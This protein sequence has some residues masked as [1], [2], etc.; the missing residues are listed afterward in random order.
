MSYCRWSEDCEVYVYASAYGGFT[1][2][3]E[4]HCN[5]RLEL[6]D[7]LN[8]LK[9]IGKKVPQEV[10]YRLQDEI[11]RGPLQEYGVIERLDGLYFSL[12]EIK[13]YTQ[14]SSIVIWDE[15]DQFVDENLVE[16]IE[17]LLASPSYGFL[18]VSIKNK[19]SENI[20]Y[21]QST[22]LFIYWMLK[23]K[24]RRLLENWPFQRELLEPLAVD[25]GVSTWSE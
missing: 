15:Y 12:T 23:N 17:K 8:R 20:F 6:I 18:S 13:S 9:S 16:N 5:T 19:Y 7:E 22:V 14:K 10:I 2:A 1:I 11:N 24:K 4:G 25:M 3:G 21:Q